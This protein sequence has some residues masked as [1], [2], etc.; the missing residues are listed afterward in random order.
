MT[1][2]GL[3]SYLTGRRRRPTLVMGHP[4]PDGDAVV[5]SVMEGWR[6]QTVDGT[7]TLPVLLC[8]AL[9]AEIAW[10]FGDLAGLLCREMPAEDLPVVLTDHHVAPAFGERV[11]AV[12]DH[13]LPAPGTDLAG[14]ETV[15]R[16]V[17]AATT[18]VAAAWRQQGLQPDATVARILLGGILLDTEGLTPRKTTR[19]DRQAVE[20]LAPLSGESPDALYAQLQDRLLSETDVG[21]LYR[22]DHRV[23]DEA[24]V[25][26]A[27]L[28][29]W[30][31]APPDTAAVR[32]LLAAEAVGRRLCVAKIALYDAEGI[33]EE[34]YLTAGDAK[35][36]ERFLAAV[37]E[38]AEGMARRVAEDEV[39]LP[40]GCPRHGR[41]WYARH[42]SQILTEKS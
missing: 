8:D 29:V 33:Q 17:G 40:A 24:D 7:P 30:R 2:D 12:V 3:R 34:H 9:P 13:H 21:T 26:F 5:S 11:V 22:R 42:L 38:Q 14:I 1:V 37:L 27:V 31:H 6:R 28:K 25:G 35:L 16:P 15:I 32:R 4:A 18:L 39:F 19:E 36:G 20:W 10:L 23:Y 41:K